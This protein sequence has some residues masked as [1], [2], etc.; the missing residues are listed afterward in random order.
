MLY[1]LNL[2]AC[3]ILDNLCSSCPEVAALS[4]GVISTYMFDIVLDINVQ[5]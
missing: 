1:A 5:I 3:G 2:P 4:L